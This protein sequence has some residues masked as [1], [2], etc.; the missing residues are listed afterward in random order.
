MPSYNSNGSR[1]TSRKGTSRAAGRP[2]YHVGIQFRKTII[3]LLL[4]MALILIALGAFTLVKV[5]NSSPEAIADNPFL[6]NGKLFAGVSIALGVCLIAG[7]AFFH[8]E[9]KKHHLENGGGKKK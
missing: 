5:N 1:A 8:Y 4:V 6:E 2:N 7:G 3:P 9:V